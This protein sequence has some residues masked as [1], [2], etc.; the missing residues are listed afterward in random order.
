MTNGAEGVP[1][2]YGITQCDEDVD[3]NSFKSSYLKSFNPNMAQFSS[4]ISNLCDSNLTI[5][6]TD[7]AEKENT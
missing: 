1:Q 6:R 4:S 2:I 7:V 5:A 3:E